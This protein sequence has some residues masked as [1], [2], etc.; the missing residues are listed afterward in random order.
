MTDGI[1]ILICGFQVYYLAFD[2]YF[3]FVYCL[4]IL[5]VVTIYLGFVNAFADMLSLNLGYCSFLLNGSN[6]I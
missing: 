4:P 3:R 5:G 1:F 2:F 6:S